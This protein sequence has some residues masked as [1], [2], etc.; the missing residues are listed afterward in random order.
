M[1]GRDDLPDSGR[2]APTKLRPLTKAEQKWVQ[3][4]LRL[5][6]PTTARQRED[7]ARLLS[8]TTSSFLLAR[9]MRA[10][11]VADRMGGEPYAPGHATR[12]GDSREDD[13]PN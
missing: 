12:D 9:R 11:R 2:D 1:A 13:G 10:A 4:H 7:I 5:A 3:H 6:P 8:S